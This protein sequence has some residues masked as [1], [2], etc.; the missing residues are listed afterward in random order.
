MK[1]FSLGGARKVRN[2]AKVGPIFF[3]MNHSA[4]PV[5]WYPLVRAC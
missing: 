5:V 2:E 4:L 1:Y 3:M